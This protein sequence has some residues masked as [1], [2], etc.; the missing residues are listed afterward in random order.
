MM[1][2]SLEIKLMINI[3]QGNLIEL[4]ETDE[5]DFLIH[6]TNCFQ[7]IGKR[8]ASGIAKAIGEKYEPVVQADLSY[9]EGDI[10]QLGKYIVIPVLTESGN[11]KYIVNLYSQYLYGGL[12]GTPTS[13]TA[14]R[15]GLKNLSNYLRKTYGT[16]IRIGTY[17][18]GCN[19]GGADWTKVEPILEKHLV[20]V[21]K[22]VRIVV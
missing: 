10:N 5:I 8:S 11:Q 16:S 18:L 1:L 14:M 17:Q 7:T 3:E 2:A 22:T 9:D 4:L 12:Y 19:R 20:S 13:Y 21:F 15:S 6:Q